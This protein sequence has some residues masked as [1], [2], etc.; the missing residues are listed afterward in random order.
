MSLKKTLVLGLL[1][2]G[3][4]FYV[5]RFD[6]PRQEAERLK[7]HLFPKTAATQ[8]ASIDITRRTKDGVQ[9]YLLE[10]AGASPTPQEE[11]KTPEQVSAEG[12]TI[13]VFRTPNS[14]AAR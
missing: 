10:N 1:L 9:Q 4:L 3:L 8:I 13:R 5:V 14:T 2:A 6:R 12:W 7:D 11:G